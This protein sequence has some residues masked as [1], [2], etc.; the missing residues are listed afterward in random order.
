MISEVNSEDSPDWIKYIFLKLR[1][2]QAKVN[3]SIG[4]NHLAHE[5]CSSIIAY[6]R[7]FKDLEP[8]KFWLQAVKAAQVCSTQLCNARE[9]DDA[10][11]LLENF[12]GA[13]TKE[14]TAHFFNI[15]SKDDDD[16]VLPDNYYNFQYR[17][18]VA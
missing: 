16:K 5:I 18:M 10:L 13:I 2:L 6:V 3:K 7:S 4:M 8:K 14:V 11:K 15:T 1:L 12:G 17:K 9:Y